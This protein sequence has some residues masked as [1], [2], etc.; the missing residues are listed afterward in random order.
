MLKNILLKLI[1]FIHILF[2]LFIILTPLSNSNYFLLL[3]AIMV[4]FIIFHWICND[5]TCIL[6]LIERKLRKEITGKDDED[7]ITCQLIEPIYDFKKNNQSLS[8]FI[9]CTTISLWLISALKLYYKYHTGSITSL[10]DLV[11][12]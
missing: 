4:P 9:Y 1:T 6:T 8:T 7:C 5:N 3:H 2:V 12:G 10:R 11:I